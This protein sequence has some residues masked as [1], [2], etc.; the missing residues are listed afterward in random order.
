MNLG[1]SYP[2][3][4]C[5][6]KGSTLYYLDDFIQLDYFNTRTNRA[7]QPSFSVKILLTNLVKL[8]LI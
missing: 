5:G 4:I 1:D 8:L 6:F 3:G 7:I 2:I